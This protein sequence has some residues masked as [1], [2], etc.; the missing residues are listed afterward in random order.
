MAE[1]TVSGRGDGS[2]GARWREPLPVGSL[3]VE[4]V[5]DGTA[6]LR[7]DMFT[8]EGTPADWS[9]HEHLLDPER[10]MTLPVG[11]F[12][13]RTGAEVVLIDAGAGVVRDDMFDCGA[14]LTNLSA[15]GIAA[16]DVTTILVTHLHTDHCGWLDGPDGPTFANATIRVGA[17]DWDYFVTTR[18][19]GRRRAERLSTVADR[20]ETIDRDGTVIAPGIVTRS[21]PGHTPGHTSAVIESGGERVIVLGDALH[22][23]AQLTETEW[24]FLY[25]T[26]PAVARRTRAALVREA[27]VAGTSLLPCHFPNMAAARLLP[28]TAK[29]QWSFT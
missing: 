20:V 5:L 29:P 6:V 3:L 26:D 8:S 4:H 10:Q 28:G 22:C 27:H 18:S 15:I 11:C 1:T 17:A 19:G 9:G 14:M 13:V 16:S 2:G 25:D 24:E 7:S 21:T 12:V 23:P